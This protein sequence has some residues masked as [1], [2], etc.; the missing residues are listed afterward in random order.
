[1]GLFTGQ[2]NPTVSLIAKQAPQWFD[3]LQA[4]QQQAFQGNQAALNAVVGMWKPVLQ[5]GVIPY[6][7]SSG[8]DQLLQSNVISTGTQAEV[9]AANAVALQEQQAAGGA[10]VLP[11]GAQ[12]A[13]NAQIAATGQQKIAEG[14]QREKLAGYQQGITTLEDAT[15]AEL[16]VAGAEEAPQLAGAGTQAGS[17]ALQ[18]G[19]EQ[20]KESQATSPFARIGQIAGLVSQG[21]G[22]VVGIGNLGSMFS[23]V[24]S[25]PAAGGA[26]ELADTTS[27]GMW[28]SEP[29]SGPDTTAGGMWEG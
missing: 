28:E 12:A 25:T 21:I 24:M 10:N 8:L 20:F 19:E 16:G 1:M 17:L 2:A 15:K 29:E 18:A 23:K 26:S 14:L 3:T 22:D 11:T 6:G 9:N 13:I 4:E 5:T 7:F 27:G